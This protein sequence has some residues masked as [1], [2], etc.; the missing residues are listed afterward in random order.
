MFKKLMCMKNCSLSVCDL[1]GFRYMIFFITFLYLKMF[2]F[3]QYLIKIQ[4]VYSYN[5]HN[6]RQYWVS[7]YCQLSKFSAISYAWCEQNNFQ[8]DDDEVHFVLD[9]HPFGFLKC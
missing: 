8:W 5:L 3:I 7:D 6:I 1:F 9:Q 4:S 2:V